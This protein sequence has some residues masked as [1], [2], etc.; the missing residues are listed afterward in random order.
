[1]L[2]RVAAGDADPRCPA[3][4][5]I[6]KAANISFG[7]GLVQADIHR[8]MEAAEGCDVLLAL[9]SQLSVGPV[10][11]MIPVAARAGAKVVVVNNEPTAMDAQASAVLRGQLSDILPQLLAE[12]AA[13]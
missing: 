13:L 3:C 6:L 11:M 7:Q 8:A 2:A 10:N 12:D 5:C 1:M 4:G 9:G